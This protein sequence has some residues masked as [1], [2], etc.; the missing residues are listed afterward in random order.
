MSLSKQLLILISLIF[1]IVF[2]VSFVLSMGNIRN[3]LEVESEIHVQDTATSLG[4]SLSPHME[5]EQDPILLTM[6]NAIFDMGYY[7]EMRLVN[8]D[9]EELVKLSNPVQMEGVPS[10]LITLVPMKTATA[11][12]EISSGWN[13]SG[14]LYVSS[15]P[16]YGYLKLYQQAKE[17][18]LFSVIIFIGAFALLML[19]LR[20]TL[21]PLKAIQ[22]QATEISKGN[23]VAIEHLP[24]TREV[25][26]V[27]QS[28]NSMSKKIGDTITRLNSRLDSLN[29]SLKRDQLTQLFNQATFGVDV[30]RALSAGNNGYVFYIKFDDLAAITKDKGNQLVDSLLR[31]FAKVLTQSTPE[32]TLAYRLYGSE[33]ALLSQQADVSS[34]T[35][36][37]E[38]LKHDITQLGQQ[39]D[40]DDMVHTGIVY[41]DRASEFD[42]L[43][44]AMVEAYEQARNIGQNA[45]FIKQD[46]ISSMT[47]QDWKAAIIRTIE[48]NS[49]EIT[50]TAEAFNYSGDVPVK[51]MEEAFTV[52]KDTEGNKLSIGTFFSMAQVFELAE[53]L[54][55]CIIN[56]IIH[57]MEQQQQATPVTINLSM[58]SVAS[59]E[60][61]NWLKARLEQSL[62]APDLLAFS[63]TAYAAAKDITAF[64]SFSGF[65]KSLGATTLL[66]RYSSDI[67]AID[68]L[69]ELHIDYI[70]LARDLTQDIRGNVSKPDFLEI[71][72]EVSSLLEIKVLAESVKADEDF[73]IVK[74]AGIFGISR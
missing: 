19:V 50:F 25:R 21:Q 4:L 41:F 14:T 23:F 1:L 65:V 67:I 46:S 36:L 37:A 42:R 11:V 40:I 43:M 33:F 54:D 73:E 53:S 20:F 69:R 44:P 13:I 28:M 17:T 63:V 39:Y 49:P 27:A 58:V 24:W 2:S 34:I 12:S 59:I 3:Y 70:R 38:Q 29:D 8:V 62:I 66:K 52:V 51:V 18:L 45:F 71:I 10:W 5:N 60:F 7:K 72:Q 15:N 68:M 30:K 56:K 6:M 22:K 64:A 16:A 26:Q 55:K 61:Q 9:G 74:Q 57:K 31:D 47:E 35:A 32:H 48:D